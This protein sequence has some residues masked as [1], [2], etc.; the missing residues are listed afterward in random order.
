MT[1]EAEQ[2]NSHPDPLLWRVDVTGLA[3][4]CGLSKQS[5]PEL[6]HCKSELAALCSL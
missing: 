2:K 3:T 6:I 5:L 1:L 4:L